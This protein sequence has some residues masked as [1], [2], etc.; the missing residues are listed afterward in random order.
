[1]RIAKRN[2]KKQSQFAGGVKWRKVLFGREL[3]RI[4]CFGTAKKQ[5][6]SPAFGRKLEGSDGQIVDSKSKLVNPA[7][8]RV[9]DLKKQTQFQEGVNECKY[10]LDKG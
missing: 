3:R 2:L 10:M 1:M 6:Q 7:V 9:C 4:S 8:F 5:S